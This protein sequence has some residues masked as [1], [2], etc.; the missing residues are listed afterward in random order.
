V[1]RDGELPIVD[2]DRLIQARAHALPQRWVA[3]LVES[4]GWPCVDE[5]YTVA[6][7]NGP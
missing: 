3:A 1:E 7:G 2:G 5:F 4:T 6:P